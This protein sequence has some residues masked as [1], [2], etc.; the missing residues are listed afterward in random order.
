[1]KETHSFL[2]NNLVSGKKTSTIDA[3]ADETEK[4]RLGRTKSPKRTV[5][6][7]LKQSSDKLDHGILFRNLHMFS[8]SAKILLWF[9]SYLKD[10]I[11]TKLRK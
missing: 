7:D 11:R 6:F 2:S 5:Y 9:I 8:V 10:R 4:C 1:M 3:S